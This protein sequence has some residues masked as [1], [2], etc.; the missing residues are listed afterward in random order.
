MLTHKYV[1]AAVVQRLGG[2]GCGIRQLC[3]VVVHSR[4]LARDWLEKSKK[5]GLHALLL[6]PSLCTDVFQALWPGD[7]VVSSVD[8]VVTGWWVGCDCRY[9]GLIH[10]WCRSARERSVAEVPSPT[11]TTVQS[12]TSNTNEAPMQLWSS[13]FRIGFT[14]LAVSAQSVVTLPY[15]HGN[16]NT[17]NLLLRAVSH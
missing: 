8:V 15:H 5:A 12:R 4:T 6:T 14:S 9:S 7:G 2:V 3:C 11:M 17:H 13:Q 1:E 10:V 16:G